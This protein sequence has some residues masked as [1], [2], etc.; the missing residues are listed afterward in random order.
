MLTRRIRFSSSLIAFAALLAFEAF[1]ARAAHAHVSIVS[2]IAYAN[3]TQEVLFGVGH[4]CAGTDTS[5][6][7]IEIPAGVGSVRPQASGFDQVDV[8]TDATG[9]VVAVTWQKNGASVLDADALYYKLSLRLKLPDTPFSTLYFPAH[10]TCTAK[11]GSTT[12]VDWVGISEA[13]GS[14]VEPAPALSIVPAR[15]PGWNKFTVPSAL[16]EFA[17]F[18]ADA[19]IVWQGNAAYSSNPATTELIAGTSGVSALSA[20]KAGDQ[21]WVRY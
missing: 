2:G 19:Q 1:T 7:Q 16:A 13:E 5:R 12:V 4:G 10:Q 21:I 3:T 15:F 11:D 17:P 9:A 20:L 6:V 14:S 8:E 18:F